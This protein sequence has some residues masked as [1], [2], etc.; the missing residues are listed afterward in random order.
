MCARMIGF[1][2]LSVNKPAQTVEGREALLT[3]T[4]AAGFTAHLRSHP[5]LNLHNSVCVCARVS[6]LSGIITTAPNSG[7]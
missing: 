7:M 4:S 2:S 5:Q 3:V 1:L 6:V